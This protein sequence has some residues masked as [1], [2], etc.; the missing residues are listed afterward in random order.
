MSLTV[1]CIKNQSCFNNELLF[2]CSIVLEMLGLCFNLKMRNFLMQ[3]LEASRKALTPLSAAI[4]RYV[5]D[6]H[7]F[8]MGS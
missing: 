6:L 2:L 8:L 4:F 1:T 7:T 5:I 3:S